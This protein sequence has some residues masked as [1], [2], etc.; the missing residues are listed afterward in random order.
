LDGG[1]RDAFE[2]ALN[3]LPEE[4]RQVLLL[5]YQVGLIVA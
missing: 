1:E 3:S 2:A 4:L 5:R